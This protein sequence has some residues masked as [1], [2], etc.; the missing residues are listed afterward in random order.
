MPLDAVVPSSTILARRRMTASHLS[1]VNNTML[2]S[3]LIS[4]SPQRLTRLSR[5]P[6]RY[7]LRCWHRV[8]PALNAP[9]AKGRKQKAA[10]KN[11]KA[12]SQ[13]RSSTS[14]HVCRA[15]SNHLPTPQLL[16]IVQNAG[17]GFTMPSSGAVSHMHF[18]NSPLPCSEC[19]HNNRSA[20]L[21]ATADRPIIGSV[22]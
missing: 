1:T 10:N 8:L 18:C 22:D 17:I 3:A 9:K 14:R 7:I 4:L 6:V 20:G 11:R 15:A 16:G 21:V 5:S 13:P 19:I 2:D 12:T